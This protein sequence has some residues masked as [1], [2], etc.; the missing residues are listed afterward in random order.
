M[1]IYYTEMIRS[2]VETVCRETGPSYVNLL[3]LQQHI[4]SVPFKTETGLSC[5]VLS[6][7]DSFTFKL[8]SKDHTT[9]LLTRL[10]KHYLLA[11]S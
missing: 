1:I 5:V 9:I 2:H 6:F 7:K 11:S 3:M 8:L 4:G 10:R